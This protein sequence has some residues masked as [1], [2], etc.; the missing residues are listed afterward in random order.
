MKR[1]H[2]LRYSLIGL[3]SCWL[4]MGASLG[5][6]LVSSSAIAPPAIASQ[7]APAA[8]AQPSQADLQQA[9]QQYDLGQYDSALNRLQQAQQ[10]AQQ[11]PSTLAVVL[12]NQSLVYQKLGNWD[13]AERV[14]RQAFAQ[15]ANLP[16]PNAA[17]QAQLLDVQGQLQFARGQV[18]QALATWKQAATLYDQ[19]G[20]GDR[21]A[22]NRINQAQALQSQGLYRYAIDLLTQVNHALAQ[23]PDTA[24]KAIALRTLGDLQRASNRLEEAEASLTASLTIGRHLQRPDLIAAAQLSLGNV[25]QSRYIAAFNRQDAKAAHYRDTTLQQYAEVAAGDSAIATQANLNELQFL[26]NTKNEQDWH[27]AIQLYP[28][29]QQQIDRLPPGRSAIYAQ[30]TF[31]QSLIALQQTK[32]IPGLQFA[33]LVQQLAT[34]E[35]LAESLGDRRS[36]SLVLGTMGYLYELSQQ[37]SD[38]KVLTR[39]SLALSQAIQADD[40][41]YRWQWQ[42]G[43]MTKGENRREQAIALYDEAYKTLQR[44]RGD[45]IAANPDLQFSFRNDVEPIYR[46]LVDLRLQQ[47]RQVSDPKQKQ[48]NLE[49]ARK[50]IDSL[51]VAELQNFFRAACLDATSQLDVVINQQSPSA[52]VIYPILLRDRLEIILKLAGTDLMQYTPSVSSAD[53][54]QVLKTFRRELQEPYT[55]RTTKQTGQQVYNWLI[56]PMRDELD[57]RRIKTLIFVLDGVLRNIPMSAL[58]DGHHYLIE[59]FAVSLELG[60]AVRN[61]VP[62]KRDAMRILAAGLV[63]PP[64]GASTYAQLPNVKAELDFISS[65]GLPA[66]IL[67]DDQFTNQQFNQSLQQANPQV[68][69]LATHGQFGVN[70]E[71]TFILDAEGKV[72]LDALAGLFKTEQ[73]GRS[74][75]VELLVLSACR[76]ATGDSRAVLGIAG[77][78]VQAGARSA[79]ASLWSLNDAASV[80]L[81]EELYRQLGQPDVTRAEALRQAQLKLLKLNSAKF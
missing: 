32:P 22:L 69:H 72:S 79:I 48:D 9:Q 41:S 67:R 12:S 62:L 50:I 61:P 43:R 3:V 25:M 5:I 46:D 81:I 68:I 42:L 73:L 51:R 35:R 26:A 15:L 47:A 55:F 71:D 80:P 18:E 65:L 14:L 52:A 45:L 58:Y 53:I 54:T 16:R 49:E 7:T 8:I 27:Q 57:R 2:W 39:R 36:R 76:T 10:Q 63:N 77:T 29:V 20:E 60:L 75:E 44:I 23:Q 24:M 6:T 28:R 59:D 70:P 33:D 78:A 56:Q 13:E 1:S 38:S 4:W 31:T 64:P 40:L 17:I 30:V 74:R 19:L 34:T 37:F 21:A 66:T 11:Q